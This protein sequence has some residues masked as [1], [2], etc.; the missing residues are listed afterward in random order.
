M[1]LIEDFDLIYW[2][3]HHVR[4]FLRPSFVKVYG[5]IRAYDGTIFLVLFGSE[6]KYDVIYRRIRYLI[7][8]KSV[9]TSIICFGGGCQKS[10]NQKQKK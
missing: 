4:I 3:Q 1:I 8:L 10:F 7:N 9:I 2:M 6:K 5:F